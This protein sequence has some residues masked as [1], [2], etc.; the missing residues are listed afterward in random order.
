MSH[1]LESAI[2]NSG[3]MHLLVLE[4]CEHGR[5]T[6]PEFMLVNRNRPLSFAGRT[7]PYT[8]RALTDGVQMRAL[9]GA[10]TLV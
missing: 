8:S 7:P 2:A 5:M 6:R 1:V 9:R 4:R 10:R 3:R